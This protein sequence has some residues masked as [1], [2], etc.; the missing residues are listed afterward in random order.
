LAILSRL[1]LP[2]AIPQPQPCDA[3]KRSCKRARTGQPEL[4]CRQ[5]ITDDGG[6]PVQEAVA[7]IKPS[8]CH[9]DER[10]VLPRVLLA[11]PLQSS[12]TRGHALGGTAL[13]RKWSK[14]GAPKL[15]ILLAV[16]WECP[17]MAA[18]LLPGNTE[19]KPLIV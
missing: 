3:A 9:I 5:N 10:L 11:P 4:G 1:E 12:Y 2:V 7:E 18:G 17:T 6:P 14:L 15:A 8:N 13:V 19:A 16:A